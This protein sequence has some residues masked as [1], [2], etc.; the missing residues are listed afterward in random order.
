MVEHSAHAISDGESQPQAFFT[1][2]MTGNLIEASEL[3]KYLRQFGFGNPWPAVPYFD[4]QSPSL[5]AAAKQHAPLL[6]VANRVGEEVL[7]DPAQHLRVGI[8][9]LLSGHNVK[10]QA[11][12]I[13]HH[14]KLSA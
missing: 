6:S 4:Q 11:A 2:F 3:L 9:P 10:I 7:H 13:G 1:L 8:H 12:I 5:A 14:L